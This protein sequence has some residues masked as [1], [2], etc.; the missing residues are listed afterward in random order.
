MR[1]LPCP[2]DPVPGPRRTASDGALGTTPAKAFQNARRDALDE[3]DD[4]VIDAIEDGYECASGCRLL[5]GP[6]T[7]VGVPFQ[8][9]PP[10]RAWWTFWLAYWAVASAEV[11]RYV[12]CDQHEG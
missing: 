11:T 4:E 5:M 12:Q 1:T 7:I 6:R 3:A 2:S 10:R 8:R 9:R